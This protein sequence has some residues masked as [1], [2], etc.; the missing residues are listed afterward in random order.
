MGLDITSVMTS[1]LPPSPPHHITGVPEY[2]N[3]FNMFPD[4]S[5][6]DPGSTNKMTKTFE[7]SF[8]I[9]SKITLDYP[10]R[11]APK[12]PNNRQQITKHV[13]SLS[14]MPKNNMSLTNAYKK[15]F[16]R[17][18]SKN[19][20]GETF[21]LRDHSDRLRDHPGREQGWESAC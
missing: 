6:M 14:K 11:V 16:A 5:C 19:H 17:K 10:R 9:L 3:I 15:C 20:L 2:S 21:R 12:T 1:E 8:R 18:K 4:D 7:E 13:D